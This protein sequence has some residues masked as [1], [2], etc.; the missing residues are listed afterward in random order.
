MNPVNPY[1]Y[2]NQF[3]PYLHDHLLELPT[4]E[5]FCDGNKAS[6]RMDNG[7]IVRLGNLQLNPGHL[8]YNVDPDG[9]LHS[10]FTHSDKEGIIPSH[11]IEAQ[12]TLFEPLVT[13][14]RKI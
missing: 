11:E 2:E 4:T 12:K 1:A 3:V 6:Y 9:T 8:K 10:R 14:L 7:V 5:I 13:Y